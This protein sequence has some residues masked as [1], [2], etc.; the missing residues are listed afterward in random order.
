MTGRYDPGAMVVVIEQCYRLCS[1]FTHHGWDCGWLKCRI[2]R[3]NAHQSRKGG[4]RFL[5]LPVRQV[6]PCGIK[7]CSFF[8]ELELERKNDR[9]KKRHTTLPAGN[10][11]KSHLIP[12]QGVMV[13]GHGSRSAPDRGPGGSDGA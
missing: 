10:L 13:R 9:E 8:A 11:T 1:P 2:W 6:K 12:D 3:Q 7:F 5:N 4:L